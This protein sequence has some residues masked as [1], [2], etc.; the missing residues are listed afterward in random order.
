MQSGLFSESDHPPAESGLGDLP[1]LAQVGGAQ[2]QGENG[3][4]HVVSEP[5]CLGSA[6]YPNGALLIRRNQFGGR[7]NDFMAMWMRYSG[8]E[9]GQAESDPRLQSNRKR[10]KQVKAPL[11]YWKRFCERTKKSN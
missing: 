11:R 6:E 4:T 9:G 1:L 8:A 7:L 10:F 2:T 3:Y 5:L